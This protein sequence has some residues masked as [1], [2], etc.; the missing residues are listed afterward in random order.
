MFH[1]VVL[2]LHAE[3]AES[4][5]KMDSSLPSSV[6]KEAK[7][8]TPNPLCNKGVPMFSALTKKKQTIFVDTCNLMG[9]VNGWYL[10]LQ[11]GQI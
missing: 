3:E 10:S 8:S 9:N 7:N 4:H 5:A 2:W 11:R 1:I 6:E